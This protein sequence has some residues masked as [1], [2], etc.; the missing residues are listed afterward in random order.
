MDVYPGTLVVKS[1]LKLAPLGFVRPGELRA[2]EWSQ[3]DFDRA[4]WIFIAS[5]TK[6]PHIVPLSRQ[7]VAILQDL[8]TLTG[9][10]KYIFSGA[11]SSRRPMSN[12]AV[13]VALRSMEIG[14][15][16]EESHS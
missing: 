3:I 10:G 9:K 13:L 1:A 16:R 4:E 14:V 2:A 12:N 5:K 6:Q 11:R 7:A 15:H 8:Q